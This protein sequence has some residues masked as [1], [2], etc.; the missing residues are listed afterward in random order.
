MS[1]RPARKPALRTGV[2]RRSF[3]E[4]AGWWAAGVVALG[5]GGLDV[6]AP[7]R[8][9]AAAQRPF[10]AGRFFLTLDGG[11]PVSLLSFEGG[12]A[13]GEVVAESLAA[14]LGGSKKHIA[15]HRF[16]PIRLRA[17]LAGSKPLLD[18]VQN[19]LAGGASRLTGSVVVAD[20][21]MKAQRR[22]DF[23]D[24]L[25]GEVTFPALDAASKEAAFVDVTLVPE[26][27][28]WV[29]AKG[30]PVGL[31][32]RA[33]SKKVLLSS[34][35]LEIPGV[36]CSGVQK[37]EALT[38]KASVPDAAGVGRTRLKMPV[39]LELPNL[40]I[41]VAQAKAK[42]FLDWHQ[43]FVVGGK[44]EDE[45]EKSA[46]LMLL[47]AGRKEALLTLAFAHVGI[48]AAAPAPAAAQA[49]AIARVKAEM[50]CESMSLPLIKV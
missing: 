38:I 31:D 16:E 45:A 34:F 50:Y 21:E 26:R 1:D 37:V 6:L 17:G 27:T 36:D 33:P 2:S 7:R 40:V 48:F 43:S 25:L 42:D 29:E 12:T 19:L 46:E 18:R 35:A 28:D 41:A 11:P 14:K 22:L 47:D 15:G 39:G 13:R 5:A 20:L 49:D 4:Q 24:A 8:A 44:N 3:L 30:E 23:F 10:A 32:A 9:S